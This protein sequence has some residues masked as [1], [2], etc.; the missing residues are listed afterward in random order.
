M[1]VNIYRNIRR[2]ITEDGLIVSSSGFLVKSMVG[3][4][5]FS[6]PL[7]ILEIGSGRGA[8]T[9][10]IIQRM[11]QQSQLDVCEI[12][13]DY[14]PWIEQIMTNHPDKQAQLHNCCVTQLLTQADTYDVILSSLPLK[15]FEG[16]KDNNAFLYRVIQALKHGLKEG[17]IYLQYQYFKSN[18][19]DIESIFGKPMDD[20]DFVPLNILPA[21]VYSMTK[22]VSSQRA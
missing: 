21:F 20:V 16:M 22:D 13:A 18:K 11:C 4:I 5:D 3:K 14:N 6:R 12:K 19:A 8:F 15:N 9:R 10:E 17:G 7:R 1:L 2:N